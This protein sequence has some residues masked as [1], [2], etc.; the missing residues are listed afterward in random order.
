[1]PLTVVHVIVM[2]GVRECGA[3]V[4]PPRA[5]APGGATFDRR[6]SNE[7]YRICISLTIFN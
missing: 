1:M 3:M 6:A 5:A 2:S 4:A 7:S